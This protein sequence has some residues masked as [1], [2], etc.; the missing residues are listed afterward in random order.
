M[1]PAPAGAA[2]EP[3]ATVM[4]SVEPSPLPTEPLPPTATSLVSAFAPPQLTITPTVQ[5]II[6]PT[7][8]ALT[9]EQRW[10]RQQIDREVF[11]QI[12]RY[13]TDG[14]NLWWYD[15]VQQEHVSLGS[16]SGE[17]D[18]QARFR[19]AGSGL[20]V[21]EVPYQVNRRYGIT[22]LSPAIVDRIQAA[23]YG[24]WIETYVIEEP[25]VRVR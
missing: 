11:P 12:Q 10:R 9:N 6:A 14:S 13:R 24:E 19:L 18:V 21:L 4:P 20:T 16:F 25:V 15:P 8:E 3:S 17:F 2:A 7:L 23:G 1:E 22:A 5:A